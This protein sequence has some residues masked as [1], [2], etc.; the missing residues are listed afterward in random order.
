MLSFISSLFYMWIINIFFQTFFNPRRINTGLKLTIWTAFYAIHYFILNQ[1]YLLFVNFIT[2]YLLCVLLC[3]LLFEGSTKKILYFCLLGQAS[4]MLIEAIAAILLQ[5]T[6]MSFAEY[7][8]L[9]SSISKLLMLAVIHAISIRKRQ[10][11][12]QEPPLLYWTLL[13]STTVSSIFII[14]AIVFLSNMTT[15]NSYTLLSAA[16]V[17]ALIFIN[18]ALY[19]VYEKL[20]ISADLQLKNA[21]MNQQITHYREMISNQKAQ[22]D[23]LRKERHNLK[24]Q[25]IALSGY[26]AHNQTSEITAFIDS[27][28]SE[29]HFGISED[30]V[31]PN[32]VLNALLASKKTFAAKNNINYKLDID[33]PK[34]LPFEDIDL[35]VLIGN[36][37]DNAFEAC[38]DTPKPYVSVT[39]Y[40][41]N[42]VLYCHFENSYTAVTV[43]DS[44]LQSTKPDSDLHGYG[45]ASIQDI[46]EK[47][48]GIAD[49]NL[50]ENIFSLKICLYTTK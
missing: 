2:V 47:Y 48:S 31:C 36:A 9:G 17:F 21:I 37:V 44:I 7:K 39:I 40:Y 24:N 50:Q 29:K 3:R 11:S 20:C 41:K 8:M 43:K 10:N 46:V 16:S 25:L 12:K 1:F 13:F 26:A 19:I 45:L 22:D 49:I 23:Y 18:V 28:L 4:G 33:V 14:F 15:E 6:G 34:T 27:L 38:I 35:S 30:S 42:F 5:S 32:L